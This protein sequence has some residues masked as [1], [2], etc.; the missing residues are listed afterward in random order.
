MD[1]VHV[2]DHAQPA[3]DVSGLVD[4]LEYGVRTV[5]ASV[6]QVQAWPAGTEAASVGGRKA[7]QSRHVTILDGYMKTYLN[8]ASLVRNPAFSQAVVVEGAAKTIYVSGQNAVRSDGTTVG[9]TLAGQ[10]RQALL[11]LQAALAAAG[12]SLKDVVRWN[13]AIVDGHPIAEG[14]AAFREA[15][16]DTADPPAISVHIVSGL[17]NPAFLVEIDAVAVA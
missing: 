8:P 2:S 12:A 1:R 9:D 13:I 17:A 6:R 15:W 14:F 11:N 4:E 5:A 10:T 3:R 16:G 7:L